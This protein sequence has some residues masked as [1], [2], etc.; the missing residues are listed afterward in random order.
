MDF[1]KSLLF[2]QATVPTEAPSAEGLTTS[3]P[4]DFIDN[5][6]DW[7]VAHTSTEQVWA[8][9]S[10][11]G[12]NLLSA[13]AVFIIGRWLARLVT[14]GIVR[15]ARRARVDETLVGFLN[16]LIYMLLFTAVCIS[17]LERLGVK[18]DSLTAV[19]AAA[20]FAIGM[21]MQGSLGNL[22][23]GVMLVFFKPFRVGDVVQVSG[24]LGRVVEIQIFNTILVTLD[25]VRIIVPNAK[26]T[27]APIQNYS[28]ERERRIDLVIGCGYND[29]LKKVKATLEELVA[30]TP[31]VLE[32]PAPV[33][34]VSSLGES[35]VDF[36]VRPWVLGQ[37]YWDVRFAL[38]EKIKLAFDEN[39]FTIP[40]PSRDLFVHT[41]EKSTGSLPLT[42][43]KAA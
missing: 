11:Y 14:A 32:H 10:T 8:T 43:L 17:S 34:A 2:A 12:P 28:A 18:S 42:E 33:V 7:V 4:P 29:D 31:G 15:A 39:G 27:D 23:S 1:G 40:F 21:A 19:L 5:A 24:N 30:A 3:N 22:A 16:N 26:I 38:T 6:V 35:S 13:I 36:V 25:N 9:V 37:D 41:P 20:G